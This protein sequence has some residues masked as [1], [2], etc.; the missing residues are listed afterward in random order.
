MRFFDTYGRIWIINI[1]IAFYIHTYY[2]SKN[3]ERTQKIEK[4]EPSYFDLRRISRENQKNEEGTQKNKKMHMIYMSRVTG[5]YQPKKSA[6]L[7]KK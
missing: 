2:I 4:N 3:D 6:N 1:A 7:A 5:K